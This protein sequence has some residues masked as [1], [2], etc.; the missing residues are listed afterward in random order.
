MN[1]LAFGTLLA[2]FIWCAVNRN[3][4]FFIYLLIIFGYTLANIL[5]QMKY[6][7]SFRRKMQLATWI[8]GGN[9]RATEQMIADYDQYLSKIAGLNLPKGAEPNLA[10]VFA[11][12]FGTAFFSM[13]K[14][15]GKITL[16]NFVQFKHVDIS[17]QVPLGPD[18]VGYVLLQ[19][20]E[21]K[22]LKQL[23]A[24]Y[25]TKERELKE[26]KNS[27][28]RFFRRLAD[29][30]PPFLF[31]AVARV[32]MV[33]VHDLGISLKI[34]GLQRHPFGVL[35]VS[36]V[37]ATGLHDSSGTLNPIMKNSNIYQLCT[38]K[39]TLVAENGK[40]V[41]KNMFVING[42]MDHRYADGVDGSKIIRLCSENQA[43][44]E[45]FWDKASLS[46]L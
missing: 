42:V 31:Q 4:A 45:K 15:V 24:E 32:L 38:P 41:I 1:F 7:N 35:T 20:V 29:H 19:H 6:P 30:L 22:T 14:C 27:T 9:P 43:N 13:K 40:P 8:D 21:E 46:E 17:I 11:K 44:F 36:D 3:G 2:H 18:D 23:T 34:I 33:I 26:G 39:Q 5:K 28:H 25:K 10:V 16:G 12:C 37:T